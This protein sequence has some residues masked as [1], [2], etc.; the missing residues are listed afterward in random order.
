MIIY[1]H[2]NIRIRHQTDGQVSPVSLS[3]VL[4]FSRIVMF[5]FFIITYCVTATIN[6]CIFRFAK[7]YAQ[8]EHYFFFLLTKLIGLKMYVSTRYDTFV[9]GYFVRGLH[10]KI[11]VCSERTIY[12]ESWFF[13]FV[14]YK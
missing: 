8:I 4:C 7:P 11:T 6:C 5:S 12:W 13:S 10:S 1:Q 3:R 14:F 9:V 2:T